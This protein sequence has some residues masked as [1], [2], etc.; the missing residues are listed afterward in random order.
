MSIPTPLFTL[1][2]FT[3]LLFIIVIILVVIFFQL[4]GRSRNAPA[5]AP[6][7]GSVN[8]RPAMQEILRLWRDPDTGRVVTEFQNRLI[9]DP[10]TLSQGERGYLV[11]LAQDWSTWLT[12]PEAQ[13]VAQVEA[14]PAALESPNMPVSPVIPAGPAVEPAPAAAA[15]VA[16]AAATPAVAGVQANVPGLPID[17]VKPVVTPLPAPPTP[18]SIVQQVDDILQEKL[19]AHP[20]PAPT[21]HLAEDPRGGV[22]VW[23]NNDKF[24]GIESVTDPQVRLIIRSAVVEWEHRTE[25]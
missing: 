24:Q 10:R 23:V 3:V 14:S 9:R 2:A 13:S 4:S 25:K 17:Q 5:G 19:A 16:A 1:I 21:I 6:K 18:P 15:D 12:V 11:R 8:A 20:T 7:K 22:F